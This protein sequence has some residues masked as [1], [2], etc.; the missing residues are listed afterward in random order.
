MDGAAG[1][2]W[3]D[4]GWHPDVLIGVL[5]FQGAYLLAVGPLRERY[6]WA[7]GIERRQVFTFTLGVLALFLA[8]H[9]PLHELSDN[10]LFFAH[11]V[12]HLVLILVVPPLLLA[13]TPPWLLRPF[14]R[15]PLVTPVARLVTFPV[16]AFV[17][18][19]LVLVLWHFPEFYDLALERHNLHIV[20]HLMFLVAATVAW[21]PVLSPLP[22]L[23]KL[24][25]PLQMLYLF[26]QS[27]PMGFLG[28]ILTFATHVV[29]EGY[30]A[31]PRLWGI[32]PLADQQMGGL[33]MKVGGGV[34]FLAAA[35]VIFFIWF[36]REES[37]KEPLLEER[38][39]R[40]Q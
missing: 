14:L 10:H 20:E 28:A 25:Y 1:F 16:T 36:N 13:G 32:S 17:M 39:A 27:L 3:L 38:R 35:S 19:N 9:S 22:E 5:L 26:F 2:S 11:M 30:V 33:I 21:W 37:A 4:W 31:D 6:G 34:G 40:Y 7:D 29:Y 12:Q 24:P 23:P 18:F 15:F 8:L